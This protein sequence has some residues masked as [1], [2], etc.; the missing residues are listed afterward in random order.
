MRIKIELNKKEY[1][2]RTV[3]NTSND[4]DAIVYSTSSEV[5][6]GNYKISFD[7]TTH[8]SGPS[9]LGFDDKIFVEKLQ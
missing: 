7:K 6:N 8:Y 1:I 5:V 9:I 2:I 4:N 3:V